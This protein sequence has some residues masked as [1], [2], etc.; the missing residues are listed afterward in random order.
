MTFTGI[1]FNFPRI[2]NIHFSVEGEPVQRPS[3]ELTSSEVIT[4][5]SVN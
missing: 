2:Q 1:Q 3:G 4:D 5:N